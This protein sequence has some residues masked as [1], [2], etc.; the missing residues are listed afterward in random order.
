[1]N[2]QDLETVK[3]IKSTLIP[4]GGTID[5]LFTDLFNGNNPQTYILMDIIERQELK[6]SNLELMLKA[7]T[8]NIHSE[9]L[10]MK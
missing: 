8:D 6:I 5:T 3:K 4:N 9:R 2:K 1:M 7:W 10:E